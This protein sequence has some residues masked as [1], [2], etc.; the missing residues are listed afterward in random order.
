MG[1]TGQ[2]LA[3]LRDYL[4]A[5]LFRIDVDSLSP[6][7]LPQGL[8]YFS[9]KGAKKAVWKRGSALRLCARNSS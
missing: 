4:R 1:V 2:R 3:R 6:A 9:R 7:D 8:E 5:G